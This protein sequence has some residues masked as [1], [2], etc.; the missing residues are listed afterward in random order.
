MDAL[1]RQPRLELGAAIRHHIAA[2]LLGAYRVGLRPLAVF[3]EGKSG[4]DADGDGGS[5]RHPADAG[6][7]RAADQARPLAHG[8]VRAAVVS[9]GAEASAWGLGY[10]PDNRLRR[11]G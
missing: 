9:I 2:G 5:L 10:P 8:D 1:R 3:L 4:C 6:D 11:A 7:L